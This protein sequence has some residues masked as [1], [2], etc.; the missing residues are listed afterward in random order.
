LNP[1]ISE[2]GG[3]KSGAVLPNL[4][5]NYSDLAALISVWTALPATVKAGILAMVRGQQLKAGS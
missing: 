2:T 5:A 4:L 3:A 1:P